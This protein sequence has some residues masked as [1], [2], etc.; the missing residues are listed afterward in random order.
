MLSPELRVLTNIFNLC[1]VTNNTLPIQIL[2]GNSRFF[3]CHICVVLLALAGG[4]DSLLETV[5]WIMCAFMEQLRVKNF[6]SVPPNSMQGYVIERQIFSYLTDTKIPA[7]VDK[8]GRG[9]ARGFCIIFCFY[10]IL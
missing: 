5:F 8:F 4:D 10:C 9:P 3:W 7:I 2:Q 1:N 6:Y